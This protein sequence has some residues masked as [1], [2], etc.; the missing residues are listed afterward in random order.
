MHTLYLSTA[1]LQEVFL[2][3]LSQ[4]CFTMT[5]WLDLLKG[6]LFLIWVSQVT[7]RCAQEGAASEEKSHLLEGAKFQ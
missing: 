2:K 1:S 3:E 5:T 6:V 4:G 7:M